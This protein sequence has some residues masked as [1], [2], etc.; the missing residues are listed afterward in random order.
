MA[1]VLPGVQVQVGNHCQLPY[2]IS[3]PPHLESL[4]LDA[5]STP[6]CTGPQSVLFDLTVVLLAEEAKHGNDTS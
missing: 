1:K 2:F 3:Y 6:E 5:F 4:S